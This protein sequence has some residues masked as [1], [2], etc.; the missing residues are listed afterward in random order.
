MHVSL[1]LVLCGLL[2]ESSPGTG[3]VVEGQ[4]FLFNV[5][6][7]SYQCMHFVH[8]IL[9]KKTVKLTIVLGPPPIAWSKFRA[10]IWLLNI[11]WPGGHVVMGGGGGMKVC[12]FVCVCA[13]TCVCA[14]VC[15]CL[16]MHAC[17]CTLQFSIFISLYLLGF[18]AQ[19]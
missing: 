7:A 14:C 5:G 16:C 17:M 13:R 12:L 1:G 6:I 4:G 9:R 11:L 2:N 8:H 10:S 3:Y 15:I 19:G 18:T